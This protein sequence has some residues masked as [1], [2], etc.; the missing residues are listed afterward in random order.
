MTG[1][2][3]PSPIEADEAR[4]LFA[5]HFA[6]LGPTSKLAI[7]VSGG[8]DSV[9]LMRLMARW[10]AEE[11][12]RP[13]LHVLTVDHG[14]RPQAAEEAQGV[15][16][17]AAELGLDHGVLTADEAPPRSGI[18]AW[19]RDLRLRLMGEWVGAHGATGVV[20][21]HHLEDQAETLAMRLARGSGL[22]GLSAMRR[23]AVIGDLLLYRPLLGVS[24]ARLRATVESLGQDWIEDPGNSDPRFERVRLR[25]A[26]AA[27]GALTRSGLDA[28]ALAASAGRLG[29]ADA[30]VEHYVAR[31]LE[32]AA[33][34]D[35]SGYATVDGKVFE[36]APLEVRLRVLARL[37]GWVGARPPPPLGAGLEALLAGLERN[38]AATL[39]GCRVARTKTGLLVSREI[40][41]LETLKLSPG[42]T[43]LWDGRFTL[44]LQ[45]ARAPVDIRPLGVAGFAA[46]QT[47]V[48]ELGSIPPRAGRALPGGFRGSSLAAPPVFTSKTA[49]ERL[50]VEF[51]LRN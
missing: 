3:K 27:K 22:S 40:R 46:A 15:A 6:T 19:A 37:I 9:A 25:K 24:G 5:S 29:R 39:G 21:A 13:C 51:C 48:A 18:Q 1:L 16:A 34:I 14:L 23:E 43:V 7:A 31:C 28:G 11:G 50:R 30:A 12:A 2:S 47:E 38:P 17:W 4:V 36:A 26:L 41:D 33:S 10:A 44:G 20:L 35:R 42:E 32:T 8:A 49:G 45:G